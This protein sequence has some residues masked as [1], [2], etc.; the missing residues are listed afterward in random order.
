MVS[1]KDHGSK[2]SNVNLA[3]LIDYGWTCPQRLFWNL[4]NN[5]EPLPESGEKYKIQVKD[6][7][8]KCKKEFILSI[9]NLTEHDEGTYSCHWRCN[10]SD[11]KAAIDLKVSDAPETGKTFNINSVL[12][13]K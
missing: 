8:S 3:C 7:Q 6:T 4:N 10:N 5:S 1:R 2:S 12:S 13:L 11:L 9:F